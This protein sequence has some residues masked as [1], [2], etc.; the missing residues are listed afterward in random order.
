MMSPTGFE[1][2]MVKLSVVAMA[3]GF[4][5]VLAI[6]DGLASSPRLKA[7]SAG[8]VLLTLLAQELWTG[9]SWL[10]C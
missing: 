8:K 5:A 3:F 4:F 1:R 6:F 9:V 2:A 7:R 10:V